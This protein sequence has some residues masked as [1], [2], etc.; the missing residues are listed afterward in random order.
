MLNIRTRTVACMVVMKRPT[1]DLAWKPRNEAMMDVKTRMIGPMKTNMEVK[2]ASPTAALNKL[3][4]FILFFWPLRMQCSALSGMC[5][6]SHTSQPSYT[7]TLTNNH[8]HVESTYSFFFYHILF[9]TF[10]INQL[11][12]LLTPSNYLLID[13]MVL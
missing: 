1:K 11:I 3:P 7:P 2:I 12:H 8:I 6:M 5:D 10:E 13:N 9:C 4:I